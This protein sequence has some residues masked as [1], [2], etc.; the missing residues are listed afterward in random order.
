[1][2]P[3]GLEPAIRAADHPTNID[4][5]HHQF[6]DQ[7]HDHGDHADTTQVKTDRHTIGLHQ[8]PFLAR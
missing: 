4:D 1:M 6:L 8:G 2:H 5:L 3:G 7:I